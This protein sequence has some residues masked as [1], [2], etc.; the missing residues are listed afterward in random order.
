MNEDTK[1]IIEADGVEK[2]FRDFWRRPRVRAVKALTFDVRPGEVFGLLG[3][4]GSGKSTTMKMLLGLLH[5]TGGR[6]SVLGAPPRDVRVKSRIGYMPEES[7][8]YPFLTAA[9]TLDFFGR[10]FPFSAEE[11][12]RRAGELLEMVGL[13][14][15]RDRLVGEFSKGM[16]RRICL[17]QA[18]IND[19]DLILLDEP[20]SGLDPIGC[21]QVKDCI[22]AL[23]ARGKTIVLSSHLLGDVEDL[24]DRIAILYNGVLCALG[25]VGDL[26]VEQDQMRI[27]L[28]DQPAGRREAMLTW[29]REQT[30]AEPR[31]DHPRR[32][33]ERFFL[34]TVR[35]AKDK[36]PDQT[37]ARVTE[38]IRLAPF[39]SGSEGKR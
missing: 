38:E 15:A 4:N 16:A 21:R 19:P 29:L 22:L 33:L 13:T 10:L 18:L 28:P 9:E 32:N 8:L 27:L 17:A 6:L 7:S 31:W 12:L 25:G 3:P 39:L 14:H 23:A 30:G 36:A 5:P 1:A 26:L 20:T 24:C 2:V 37:G 11:R 35:Q 34:D